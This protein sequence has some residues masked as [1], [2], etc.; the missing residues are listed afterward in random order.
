MINKTG[1]QIEKD[2]FRMFRESGI[3]ARLRGGVYRYGMRPKDSAAEDAV[4]R[5]TGGVPDRI[6]TG[7][8]T[9]NIYV[10]GVDVYGDGIV[11]C[12]NERCEDIEVAVNGWIN[13]LTSIRHGYRLALERIVATE[14]EP[15]SGQYFVAVRLK[16]FLI[17]F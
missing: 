2:I 5:F 17:T 6:Q 15:E 16:C 3:P 14:R 13:S 10:P 12:D 1:Q 4:V 8:A 7:S 9:I 11:R